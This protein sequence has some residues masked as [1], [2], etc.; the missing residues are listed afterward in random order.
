M[1]PVKRA[2]I[3]VLGAVLSV[4]VGGA[5]EPTAGVSVP[6]TLSA[7]I[8]RTQ[9]FDTANQG[10]GMYTVV[11][12]GFRALLRPGIKLG[13]HWFVYS[14]VQLDERPYSWYQAYSPGHRFEARVLQAFAGYTRQSNRKSLT[15][16]AGRL[17]SAFGS[18]ALRYE[19]TQNPLIDVPLTYSSY[20]QVRGDQLPCGVGDFEF[21]KQIPYY[22]QL[23]CGPEGVPNYGLLPVTLYGIP[24][25]EADFSDNR[26]DGRFQLT[27]SSPANP[28]GIT[29]IV[30]PQWTA[31]GG[32]TI[33]QGF[34]VGASAYRGPFFDQSLQ[35]FLPART[36]ARNFPA[37]GLGVDAQWARGRWSAQGEWQ[38]FQFD[39]PNFQQSP[40]L[41]DGYIEIKSI[42]SPRFYAAIRAGYRRYG[43]VQDLSGGTVQEFL[44]NRASYEAALGWHVNRSQLLKVGY[45]RLQF[46]DTFPAI[47]FIGVQFVTSIN[48]LSKALF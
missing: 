38:R 14:A 27:N 48:S 34:R 42:L 41:T 2:A 18:F 22:A 25:L 31:G 24:G 15:V 32:I 1:S 29:R 5:Q 39:Y 6:I 30:E 46:S 23:N 17:P 26:L 43:R 28:Q 47:D 35:R 8:V 10:R 11:E 37:T 3:A 19:D 44:Q 16:K 36:T 20:V 45:E 33:R 9:Q 13:P 4:A 21:P 12:P 40:A 7:G